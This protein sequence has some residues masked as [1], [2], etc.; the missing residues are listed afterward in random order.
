MTSGF[1][2]MQLCSVAG[3]SQLEGVGEVLDVAAPEGP[4]CE[5]PREKLLAPVDYAPGREPKPEGSS[6]TRVAAISVET[7][8][9]ATKTVAAITPQGAACAW[10]Q[11]P[12]K[13]AAMP[14]SGPRCAWPKA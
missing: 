10:P 14:T 9:A 4:A 13:K 3:T 1:T 11:A 8:V 2:K 6:D 5:W 7:N 12:S